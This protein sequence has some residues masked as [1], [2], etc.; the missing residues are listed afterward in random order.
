MGIRDVIFFTDHP[1]AIELQRVIIS[2]RC[3]SRKYNIFYE[4]EI[5]AHR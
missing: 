2:V 1:R 5:E 3:I 4:K